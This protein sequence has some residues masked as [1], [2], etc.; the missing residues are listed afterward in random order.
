M[1]WRSAEDYKLIEELEWP[2][3]WDDYER[4]V[5]VCISAHEEP[6]QRF[7]I[8]DSD[9][10]RLFQQLRLLDPSGDCL[11]K[12]KRSQEALH[13]AEG[14]LRSKLSLLPDDW[15]S[16]KTFHR[17]LCVLNIRDCS[18]YKDICKAFDKMHVDN[19][20]LVDLIALSRT[21]MGFPVALKLVVRVGTK[22]ARGTLLKISRNVHDNEAKMALLNDAAVAVSVKIHDRHVIPLLVNRLITVYSKACEDRDEQAGSIIA[23]LLEVMEHTRDELAPKLLQQLAALGGD[24]GAATGED[25]KE[26]SQLGIKQ[27]I[28]N[29]DLGPI[30]EAARQEL[31]RRRVAS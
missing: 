1:S 5:S 4:A 19:R 23:D 13:R 24:T 20:S 16:D 28:I 8:K 22:E 2:D 15:R 9:G 17:M 7:G 18:I 12:I 25:G 26:N 6:M 21:R 31:Q 29:R 30:R 3:L 10:G 14:A 11:K 27:S